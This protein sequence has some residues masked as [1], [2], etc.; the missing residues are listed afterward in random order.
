M[1]NDP[2]NIEVGEI[3]A[4]Y[5][6]FIL[7][8]FGLLSISSLQNKNRQEGFRICSIKLFSIRPGT[9]GMVKGS[10][11]ITHP[12]RHTHPSLVLPKGPQP[13]WTCGKNIFRSIALPIIGDLEWNI[14]LPTTSDLDSDFPPPHLQLHP[15]RQRTSATIRTCTFLTHNNTDLR[16]LTLALSC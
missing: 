15:R 8:L 3:E 16:P 11:M 2:P 14:V 9:P 12:P 1:K 4:G 7:H 13:S 10:T 5:S 6:I